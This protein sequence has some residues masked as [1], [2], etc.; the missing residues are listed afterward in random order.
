MIGPKGEL[1]EESFDFSVCTP[2]WLVDRQPEQEYRF[3]RHHLLLKRY[4]YGLLHQAIQKLCDSVEGPNWRAVAEKLGRYGRWEF[5]DY[6]PA[7]VVAI[8]ERRQELR[9]RN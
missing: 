8:G 3:V 7:N 1:G 5:E 2:S 6:I 4:D 9:R